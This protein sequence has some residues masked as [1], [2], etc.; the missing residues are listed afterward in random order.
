MGSVVQDQ[1]AAAPQIAIVGG[2][3]VGVILALGLV[4]QNMSVRVYEQA[5]GFREVGAGIAFSACAR[6]C[7]S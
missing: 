4:R 2:G 7:S 1:D 6:R 5:A 3:I